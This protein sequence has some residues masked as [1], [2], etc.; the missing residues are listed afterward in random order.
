LIVGALKSWCANCP[1]SIEDCAAHAIA[2]KP[3]AR[4]LV[5]CARIVFPP[6]CRKI[7]QLH[8]KNVVLGL[9]SR[10][11]K[12]RIADQTRFQ[13]KLCEVLISAL[14]EMSYRFGARFDQ[15][16]FDVSHLIPIQL[17]KDESVLRNSKS[18]MVGM[19]TPDFFASFSRD[20][21]RS[22]AHRVGS[23]GQ[24]D[25]RRRWSHRLFNNPL[26]DAMSSPLAP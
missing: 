21:Q 2:A 20:I 26:I 23:I 15:I 25:I 4:I 9:P 18:R 19:P 6:N 13:Q 24:V 12:L 22:H 8:A 10:S 5:G 7:E 1:P 17:P 3:L 14:S 16:V 11:V